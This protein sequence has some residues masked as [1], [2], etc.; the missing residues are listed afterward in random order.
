VLEKKAD[1]DKLITRIDDD[2]GD[3]DVDITIRFRLSAL[4]DI[5]DLDAYLQI[6][7]HMDSHINLMGIGVV[8]TFRT[9]ADVIRAWFPV[10]RDLYGQRILR[11]TLQLDMRLRMYAN[12][13]RFVCE[14]LSMSIPMRSEADMDAT[15]ALAKYDRMD[16]G[17]VNNPAFV[18]PADYESACLMGNGADFDYLLDISDKQKSAEALGRYRKIVEDMTRERDALRQDSIVE[19]RMFSGALLWLKE[20]KELQGAIHEGMKTG[21]GI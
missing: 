14:C 4:E 12:I 11:R 3:R 9:Y 1:I 16:R 5:K 6:R 13:I 18:R 19:A 8:R 7:D 2:S 20:L 15:L 10:R 17:L 21:W